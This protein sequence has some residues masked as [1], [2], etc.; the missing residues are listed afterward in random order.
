MKIFLSYSR[1]NKEVIVDIREL[2][3]VNPEYIPWMDEHIN[4]GQDWWDKILDEIRNCDLFI[5][6]LSKH[7]TIS[8][9]CKK[10]LQYAL[11]LEKKILPIRLT[12]EFHDNDLEKLKLGKKHCIDWDS[13]NKFGTRFA[14]DLVSKKNE[15]PSPIPDPEP[16]RPDYPKNTQQRLLAQLKSQELLTY[17]IQDMIYEELVDL[18]HQKVNR[19]IYLFDRFKER[20]ELSISIYKKIEEFQ[21]SEGYKQSI[22]DEE[23]LLLR[24]KIIRLYDELYKTAEEKWAKDYVEELNSFAKEIKDDKKSETYYKESYKIHEKFWEGNREFYS[25]SY[26]ITVAG[27]LKYAKNQN[28]IIILLEKIK[29][30]HKYLFDNNLNE[31]W[32]EKYA[33][34]LSKLLEYSKQEQKMDLYKE[35]QPVYEY[36]FNSISKE[37]WAKEYAE[38]LS[39]LLEDSKQEQKINLYQEIKRVYEYLFYNF[40]EE[41][42]AEKYAETLSKLLEYSKQEQKMDLYKDIH[43]VYEYLYNTSNAVWAEKYAETLSI[44]LESLDQKQKMV[45]YKEMKPVYEYLYNKSE[46]IWAEKYANILSELAT[47]KV[48]EQKNYQLCMPIYEELSK[49]NPNYQIKFFQIAKIHMDLLETPKQEVFRKDM[50]QKYRENKHFIEVFGKKSLFSNIY[51]KIRS[52]F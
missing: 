44:L 38:T 6:L 25:K 15:Q 7:Y 49:Q 37:I 11:D 9:Y 51:D 43:P 18:T 27:L 10:E 33:E 52:V 8:E 41:I 34:T 39:K 36:L 16:S 14:N 46:E 32:A 12:S 13:T 21:K 45:L 5:C 42:Y 48:E 4:G 19:S 24:E 29:P 35:M 23:T 22:I 1:K 30:I 47:N 28:Q 26:D 20:N 40:T 31:I 50:E 17:D 3:R 2:I